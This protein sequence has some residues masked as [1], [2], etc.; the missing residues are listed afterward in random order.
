MAYDKIISPE[1]ST[2]VMVNTRTFID[3]VDR[4]SLVIND[5]LKSLLVC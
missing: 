1:V 2:T 3:A 5:R 4:V